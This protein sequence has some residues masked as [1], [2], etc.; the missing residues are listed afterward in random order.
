M[1]SRVGEAVGF[2]RNK[3][4]AAGDVLAQDE[5]YGFDARTDVQQTLMS[6]ICQLAHQK[7]SLRGGKQ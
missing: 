7:L 2:P 3:A 4:Q 5:V 6:E 1:V